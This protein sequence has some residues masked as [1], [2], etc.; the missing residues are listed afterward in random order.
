MTATIIAAP[1]RPAIA[2]PTMSMTKFRDNAAINEPI[3]KTTIAIIISK[4]LGFADQGTHQEGEE[5][6]G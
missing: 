6:S 1:P 3:S 2:R 4:A 5:F